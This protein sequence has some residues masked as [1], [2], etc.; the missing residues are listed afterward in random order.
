MNLSFPSDLCHLMRL[1][2]QKFIDDIPGVLAVLQDMTRSHPDARLN[3]TEAYSQMSAAIEAI[4]STIK[5]TEVP[6]ILLEEYE[7][8]PTRMCLYVYGCSPY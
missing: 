4:A 1:L 7:E 6:I 5:D 8:V 2:L 3:A